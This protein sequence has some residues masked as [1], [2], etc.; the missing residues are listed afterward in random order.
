MVIYEI[1]GKASLKLSKLHNLRLISLFISFLMLLITSFLSKNNGVQERNRFR[2][3]VN[4][5]SVNL[6]SVFYKE[7]EYQPTV[8]TSP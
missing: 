2:S 8:N 5:S 1:E 7:S 4:L 3:Q 6:N